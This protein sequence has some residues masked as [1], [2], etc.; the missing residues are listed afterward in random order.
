VAKP[1]PSLGLRMPS[2]GKEIWYLSAV[3]VQLLAAVKAIYP[4]TVER[5]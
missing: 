1:A 5:R 2:T 4:E 3:L